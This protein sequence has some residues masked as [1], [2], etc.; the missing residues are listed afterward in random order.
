MKIN[1]KVEIQTFDIPEEVIIKAP[2]MSREEGFTA[3]KTINIRELDVETLS[4]LCDIFKREVFK[5]ARK[6]MPPKEMKEKCSFKV[7]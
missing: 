3:P 1:V 5:K 6:R 2:P 4:A 7:S